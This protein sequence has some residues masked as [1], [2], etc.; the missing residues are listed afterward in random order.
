MSETESTTRSET[1]TMPAAEPG[2]RVV[3]FATQWGSYNAG[4][5]A[6]FSDMDADALIAQGVATAGGEGLAD[7]ERPLDLPPG[8]V[9]VAGLE[10]PPRR[11][12]PDP[13]HLDVVQTYDPRAS[14]QLERAARDIASGVPGSAALEDRDAA[15][16]KAEARAKALAEARPAQPLPVQPLP[17]EPQPQREV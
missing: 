17:A 4:E 1:E 13:Q 7:A 3:T 14:V 9:M 2:G 5:S 15:R 8:G 10:H 12:P 11:W 16:A 6:A